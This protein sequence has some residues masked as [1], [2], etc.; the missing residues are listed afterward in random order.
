MVA[1]GRAED[2][3]G[4]HKTRGKFKNVL[5]SFCRIGRISQ[6]SRVDRIAED[7]HYFPVLGHKHD[8]LAFSRNDPYISIPIQCNSASTFKIGMRDKNVV[9][10]EG[11]GGE[12]GIATCFAF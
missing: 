3:S 7:F 2:F 5:V 10:T 1:L 4:K 11:V 9:E 6:A 8:G 12:G